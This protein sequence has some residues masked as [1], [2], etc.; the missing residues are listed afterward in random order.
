[1]H[2]IQGDPARGEHGCL[3]PGKG[4]DTTQAQVALREDE[5]E[6]QK[7]PMRW[8]RVEP[9]GQRRDGSLLRKF[10]TGR[11]RSAYDRRGT[12]VPDTVL[13]NKKEAK[14]FIHRPA[15]TCLRQPSALTPACRQALTHQSF[16]LNPA[17]LTSVHLLSR[18]PASW[19][20]L[21]LTLTLPPPA[22][23]PPP[24]SALGLVFH[25]CIILVNKIIQLG[26]PFQVLNNNREKLMELLWIFFFNKL[27]LVMFCGFL[28]AHLYHQGYCTHNN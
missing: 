15:W 8:M 18:F 19:Q 20:R 10:G 14:G 17:S 4:G 2:S 7:I 25:L 1:M 6:R 9:R 28:S 24:P 16:S 21:A 23:Q 11:L 5:L 26:N 3:H 22:D 12:T 13:N 27:M